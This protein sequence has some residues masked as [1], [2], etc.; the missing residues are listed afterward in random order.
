MNHSLATSTK[1]N[2]KFVINGKIA[3]EH[4][5]EFSRSQVIELDFRGV[6][7]HRICYV[8]FNLFFF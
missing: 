7:R 2:V 1:E 6:F 5:S 3:V 4:D 8:D